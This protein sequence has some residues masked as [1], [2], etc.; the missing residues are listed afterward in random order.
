MLQPS[1]TFTLLL[2][3][4]PPYV[5]RSKRWIWPRHIPG[6]SRLSGLF[7]IWS[8]TRV[9]SSS[10]AWM[11]SMARTMV[12]VPTIHVLTPNMYLLKC[13]HSVRRINGLLYFALW[14]LNPFIPYTPSF[15][16]F[17]LTSALL[18]RPF[19]KSANPEL[20]Q[21][22]THWLRTSYQISRNR[23]FMLSLCCFFPSSRLLLSTT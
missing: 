8:W 19:L 9:C 4:D 22:F 14:F 6:V 15:F 3:S 10:G 13:Q 5:R 1:R 7:T 12:V 16:H 23:S 18:T 17:L 21:I 20:T 2:L 11:T